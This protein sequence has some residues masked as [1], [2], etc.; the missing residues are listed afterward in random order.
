[1]DD[2]S[3][4]TAVAVIARLSFPFFDRV[5]AFFHDTNIT[6]SAGAIQKL[7]HVKL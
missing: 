4:R 2:P 7:T 6:A 1:V 3:P 5:K